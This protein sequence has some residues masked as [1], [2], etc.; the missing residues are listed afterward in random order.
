MHVLIYLY[1]CVDLF[2][3]SFFL[4]IFTAGSV[5]VTAFDAIVSGPL[6]E[7]MSLSQKIGG[8]VLKHVCFICR[9]I[10]QLY[11]SPRSNLETQQLNDELKK[12]SH[13]E[14]YV[15]PDSMFPSFF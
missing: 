11:L 1:Y 10:K 2:L 4:I 3:C 15:S 6:A 5:Y 12:S 9:A 8:D 13:F 14:F 7:Y